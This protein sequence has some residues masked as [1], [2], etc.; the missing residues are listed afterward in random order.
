MRWLPGHRCS[1][2]VCA[3]P[4]QAASNACNF[5]VDEY[6]TSIDVA[7]DGDRDARRERAPGRHRQAQ[8]R[9][10]VGGPARLHGDARLQRGHPARR[11]RTTIPVKVWVAVAG[12]QHARGRAAGRADR[13]SRRTTTITTNA[14]GAFVERDAD[15]LHAAGAPRPAVDGGRRRRGA[16][17]GARRGDHRAAADRPQR[18]AADDQGQ[19]RDPRRPEPDPFSMDCQPGRGNDNGTGP[20]P[21]RAGGVRHPPGAVE[22]DVHERVTYAASASPVR[23]SSTPPARR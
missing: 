1:S 18:R 5:S 7:L 19:P 3:A 6:W 2:L 9:A 20:V 23:R 22:R 21:E 12:D 17:P 10:R 8:R 15:H 16:Q 13:R 14:D 11:A 4:A